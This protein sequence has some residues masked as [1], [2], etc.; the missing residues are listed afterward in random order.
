MVS[1][2][3][4]AERDPVIRSSLSQGRASDRMRLC[5]FFLFFPVMSNY[6]M[7]Y[8]SKM[9]PHHCISVHE[10]VLSHVVSDTD[11]SSIGRQLLQSYCTSKIVVPDDLS[12]PNRHGSLP[13]HESTVVW[14][15]EGTIKL[16]GNT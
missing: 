4:D 2:R 10:S 3:E 13:Y 15:G 14:I 9:Q 6:L 7:A 11:S 16:F 12:Q 1:D 8:F 5:A